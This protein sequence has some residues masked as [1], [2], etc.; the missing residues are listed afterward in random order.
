MQLMKDISLD[1]LKNIYGG[2]N[3]I[4]IC[5]TKPGRAKTYYSN[6]INLNVKKCAY[7]C[8]EADLTKHYLYADDDDNNY[9]SGI[10][11]CSDKPI[12]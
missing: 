10:L 2:L 3:N 9:D 6:I 8:C 12:E 4:C 1:N 11:N 5:V 7:L